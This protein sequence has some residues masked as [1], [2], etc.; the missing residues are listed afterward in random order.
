M[1][2]IATKSFT[3]ATRRLLPG[4]EFEASNRDARLLAATR[5]ARQVRT[6]T[7][8]PAPPPELAEK[9]A[10]SV[11]SPAPP[12]DLYRPPLTPNG[13]NPPQPL[14]RPADDL[15]A[16]RAEYRSA[17]GRQPFHQWGAAELRE[18]IAAA[19]APS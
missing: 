2:L 17:V 1:K 10:A 18:K 8:L 9:I 16:L 11:A 6:T 3:Y 15:T 4:D 19:K 13:P 7:N 5:K 14:E 12:T